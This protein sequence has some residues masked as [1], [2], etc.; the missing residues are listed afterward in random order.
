MTTNEEKRNALNSI[1]RKCLSEMK[2]KDKSDIVA[3]K[4]VSDKWSKKVEPLGLSRTD[5]IVE[6]GYITGRLKRNDN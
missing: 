2:T 3:L 4:L 1:A 5:L 6:I